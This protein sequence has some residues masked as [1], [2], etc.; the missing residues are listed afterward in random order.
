MKKDS[1]EMDILSYLAYQPKTRWVTIQAI[2][3][4]CK[5]AHAK[6]RELVFDL[7]TQDVLEI[8]DGWTDSEEIRLRLKPSLL[9]NWHRRVNSDERT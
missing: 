3:R 5:V 7:S 6:A 9:H 8:Q 2:A 1:L 4:H